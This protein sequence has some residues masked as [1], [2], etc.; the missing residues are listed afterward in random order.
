[1]KKCYQSTFAP[2]LVPNPG[3]PTPST[4]SLPRREPPQKG[5]PFGCDSMAI[6]GVVPLSAGRPLKIL[7]ISFRE[8]LGS[9]HTVAARGEETYHTLGSILS[10][11]RV[12]SSL[13]SVRNN[14][15]FFELSAS[16]APFSDSTSIFLWDL[17][18]PYS[19]S[20]YPELE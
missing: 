13:L 20:I 7:A 5:C 1:M 17:L 9:P 19:Q 18:F 8:N 11:A 3:F 14:C 16:M 4:F 12:A 2:T 10:F 15:Q 6:Q